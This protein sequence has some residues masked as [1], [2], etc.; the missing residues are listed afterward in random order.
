MKVR[1]PHLK[2]RGGQIKSIDAARRIAQGIDIIERAWG[3]EETRVTLKD[4]F[5]CPDIDSFALDELNRT[6]TERLLREI[7]EKG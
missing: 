7:I 2:L 5:V 4:V 3:I 1:R 6:P